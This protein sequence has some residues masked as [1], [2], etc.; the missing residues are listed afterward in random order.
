MCG[1]FSLPKCEYWVVINDDRKF[2]TKIQCA[3]AIWILQ[4]ALNCN[5]GVRKCLA[6]LVKLGWHWHLLVPH[7]AHLW[8]RM[9]TAAYSALPHPRTANFGSEHKPVPPPSPP[10]PPSVVMC[11]VII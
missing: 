1:R 10:S 5:S 6:W 3:A 2:F 9:L 7:F 8:Q 11:V 4:V